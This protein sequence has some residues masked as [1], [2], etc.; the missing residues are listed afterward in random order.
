MKKNNSF[1][2]I[3]DHL[4]S[5]YGVPKKFPLGQANNLQLHNRTRIILGKRFAK[6]YFFSVI[7][8]IR[9]FAIII[10]HKIKHLLIKHVRG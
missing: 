5:R 1:D 3:I 8:I 4:V 9:C 2:Q 7:W 6:V 10:S